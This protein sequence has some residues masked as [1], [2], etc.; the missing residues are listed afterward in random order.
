MLLGFSRTF[1]S[2]YPADPIPTRSQLDSNFFQL[3]ACCQMPSDRLPSKAYAKNCPYY[4]SSNESQAGLVPSLSQALPSLTSKKTCHAMFGRR[5]NI[6]QGT[7]LWRPT[8]DR[9]GVD[10]DCQVTESCVSVCSIRK[11]YSDV[12]GHGKKLTG[13]KFRKVWKPRKHSNFTRPYL[14]PKLLARSWWPPLDLTSGYSQSMFII[15]S[16]FAGA[17][18]RSHVKRCPSVVV[19]AVGA[20][21]SHQLLHLGKK[22]KKLIPETSKLGKRSECEKGD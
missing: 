13:E 16:R 22:L 11:C 7:A 20:L 1:L 10:K 5:Q 8:V 4:W 15:L 18:G 3:V 14:R 21:P 17:F 19:A 12:F 6:G 9:Q 2:G